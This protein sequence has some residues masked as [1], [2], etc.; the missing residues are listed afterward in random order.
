MQNG[1]SGLTGKIL[2]TSAP[3]TSDG[4]NGWYQ[5][6]VGSGSLAKTYNFYTQQAAPSGVFTNIVSDGGA[7]SRLA[8]GT[9]HIAVVN[10]SSGGSITYAP[11]YW[12]SANPQAGPPPLPPPAPP[13]QKLTPVL[14]GDT[15]GGTFDA[16]SVLQQANLAFSFNA[17]GDNDTGGFNIAK[18][19]LADAQHPSWTL[20]PVVAQS[21]L[22][23]RWSTAETT[24]FW[25]G[26]YTAYMEQFK[27]G[28]WSLDRPV[29]Y[30]T[31]PVTFTVQ[32]DKLLLTATPDSH[33]LQLSAG[34]SAT[35]GNWIELSATGS[36]LPNG[37]LVV[38]A[39]DSAGRMLARDGETLTGSLDD[40]ALGRIGSVASDGLSTVILQRQAARLPAGRPP[41]SLRRRCRRRNDR[42]QSVRQ[43]D[44]Q[45]R[46]ARRPCQRRL[47]RDQPRGQGEQRA[48]PVGRAGRQPAPGPTSPWVYLN[49]GSEVGVDLTW[50]AATPTRCFRAARREPGRIPA[51]ARRRRRLRQYR[52]LPHRR[53]EHSES[54]RPR[55][56]PP[57]RRPRPGR[58]GSQPTATTRRS[59]STSRARSHREASVRQHGECPEGASTSATSGRIPSASRT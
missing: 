59:W 44:R 52:C 54:A 21:D 58:C 35:K 30:A 15:A 9:P 16:L 57:A 1:S 43:R 41:A 48:R 14:V 39:T 25:D 7:T 34:G 50:S 2:L 56:T 18:I 42:C 10:L 13:L 8:S 53:P 40:A 17:A 31:V 36:T 45:R 51:M 24:Q 47:R 23:G 3:V 55:D 29:G 26:T 46:N 11:D 12:L 37:T 33:S 5:L 19:V 27:P 38:Y 22:Y 49:Q 28:N 4:S 32:L 20:T 6:V